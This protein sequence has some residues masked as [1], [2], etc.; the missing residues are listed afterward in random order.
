MKSVTVKPTV[1]LTYDD[2]PSEW[3]PALLDVLAAENARAT[4]FVLGSHIATNEEALRQAIVEGHE[5]G[6]HGW[7]HTP[8]DLLEPVTLGQQILRT[9]LTIQRVA[10]TPVR[11][12][13]APWHR[14]NGPAEACAVELGYGYCRVTLDAGD[15][16]RS[17]DWI[18]ET[19]TRN[20][21]NGAVVGLHD[22]IAPNGDQ[23]KTTRLDTVRATERI[24]ARCKSV[25]VSEMLG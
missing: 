6:I 16:S 5:I 18:V 11:W 9:D 25:T 8:A 12:W 23:Q 1:A 13:R 19:V 20:L 2:G 14:V 24:L 10:H 17:E 21:D 4:F 3:T 7:D 15:V 22:G